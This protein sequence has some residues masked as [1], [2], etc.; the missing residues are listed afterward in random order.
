[1]VRTL[2]DQ[3]SQAMVPAYHQRRSPQGSA[4]VLFPVCPQL[5]C[6]RPPPIAMYSPSTNTVISTI[7]Q[8][9]FNHISTITNG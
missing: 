1:N 3:K 4:S 2:T 7:L 5:L 8:R 9:Y 6:P